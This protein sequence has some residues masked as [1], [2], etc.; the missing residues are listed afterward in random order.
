M[1]IDDRF[2]EFKAEFPRR[3]GHHCWPKAHQLALG[4][5]VRGEATWD[6]LIAGAQRYKRFLEF[7]GKLKTEFVMMPTTWLGANTQGWGEDY[8][9]PNV[10]PKQVKF[11]TAD[12]QRE[13]TLIKQGNEEGLTRAPGES[14]DSFSDRIRKAYL[15]RITPKP[16]ARPEQVSN[17]AGLTSIRDLT[18]HL[19]IAK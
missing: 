15:A 1:A 5:V 7:T 17:P 2:E 11:M 19:R 18:N 10:D 8:D 3:A 9:L 4:V 14:L 13:V 16:Q 6:E 12:Q